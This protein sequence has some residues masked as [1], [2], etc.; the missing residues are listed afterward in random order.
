M[1]SIGRF[2]MKS[3]TE[4]NLSIPTFFI[5]LGEKPKTNSNNSNDTTNFTVS[6]F[7]SIW[8]QREMHKRHPRF[9]SR[10]SKDDDRFYEL[11]TTTTTTTQGPVTYLDQHV[12]E[13]MHTYIYRTDLKKRIEQ[14]LQSPINVME[15][16]WE[17]Q[18]S[19]GPLGSSGAIPK[20]RITSTDDKKSI[21][22]ILLF[23]AHHALGDG[24]SLNAAIGDL[25]DEAHDL[26]QMI[27]NE[28]RRRKLNRTKLG[29]L[30]KMLRYVQR[31]IWFLFTSIR[32]FAFH[33]Y[34]LLI[35]KQNPF[36]QALSISSSSMNDLN[37][38]RTV[39]WCDVAPLDEAKIIAKSIGKKVTLNDLFVSCVT[40]A[41]A[42]QIAEHRHHHYHTTTSSKDEIKQQG[43]NIT[44]YFN[45]CCPVHLAGGILPPG[46]G[47]GNYIG[48]FVAQVPGEM[49]NNTN[50]G[51]T[52]V[53][54]S[55]SERLKKVHSSM[56]KHKNG[57]DS[58][59]S[60]LIAK[61]AAD[62]LPES[63]AKYLF[64]NMNGNVAAVVSNAKG[65][66][67]KIHIDGRPVEAMAG[68]V[69]LPPGVPVGVVVQ[70]YNGIVSLSITAE[71]WA[72]PDSDQFM[73]WILEEYQRL[74]HE[75]S[76]PTK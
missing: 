12:K 45:I 72:I 68:F 21:E 28:I 14:M 15:K 9:H 65:P 38:E 36:L 41:I 2:S 69:P 61:T 11:D 46:R 59:W 27:A 22:T 60:Y 70:S 66:P 13:S 50:N 62:W 8:L 25:V 48:A 54:V 39:S 71:K 51:E 53:V 19:N 58:I 42:R 55:A 73:T 17:V 40:A 49:M 52:K 23:R 64:V 74:C 75:V 37:H 29:F 1:T 26:R 33:G 67:Q 30:Q 32:S 3:E 18:I 4:T 24:V 5:A 10:V 35:T 20:H 63:W 44:P 47:I 34:L 76:S 6:D 16:L 7:K 43:N 31:M 56:W 57:P